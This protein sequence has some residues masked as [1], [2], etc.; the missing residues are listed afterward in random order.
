MMYGKTFVIEALQG[1]I[2]SAI[3]IHSIHTIIVGYALNYDDALLT[4]ALHLDYMT[5][6][7]T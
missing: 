1:Q 2:I 6:N 3:Y 7:F 5:Y 4:S